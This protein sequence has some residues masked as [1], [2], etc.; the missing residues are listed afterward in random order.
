MIGTR[1]PTAR[2]AGPVRYWWLTLVVLCAAASCA[3]SQLP[4][5]AYSEYR[6]D[7]I[8]GRGTTAQAGLGAVFLMGTY[9]RTTLDA[10]AGATWHYD[11]TRASGRADVIARFLLDP[12]REARFGL[13]LG[14]GVS[15]PYTS[16]ETHVR[17]FLTAV[18]DVE[19]RILGN[20]TPAIQVGLGGGTRIGI[21]LRTSPPRWR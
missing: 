5:P 6:G 7:G 16:G 12:F 20:V 11:E 21:A 14:G 10:A 1:P 17:P 3:H 8:V 19:G 18:V 2:L 13:S 4:T 9:V 15:V